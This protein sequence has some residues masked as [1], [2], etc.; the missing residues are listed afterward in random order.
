MESKEM[1]ENRKK[2]YLDKMKSQNNNVKEYKDYT[3][4]KNNHNN[5]NNDIPLINDATSIYES[6]SSFQND[7]SK[8]GDTIPNINNN[9]IINNNIDNYSDK[10]N[11]NKID[12]D[13]LYKKIIKNE[14]LRNLLK[15][16]KKI[17]IA[18]L[19]MFH[20]YNIYNLDDTVKFKYT[21]LIIEI[22]SL[23]IDIILK[24][25]VKRKVKNNFSNNVDDESKIKYDVPLNKYLKIINKYLVDLSF[26]DRIF[27][28]FN[29][30]MDILVDIA[31][32]FMV[33]FI[34]FIIHEQNE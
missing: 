22:S 15:M 9:N 26:L 24:N 3:N 12:Y 32:I 30:F 19:S 33:N 5:K 17:L 8:G 27:E 28:I 13:I 34:F 2:K 16:M 31:I 29:A 20:C 7:I 25:I 4:N 18:I 23:F 10:N 11:I 6:S 1:K 21:L 14:Y